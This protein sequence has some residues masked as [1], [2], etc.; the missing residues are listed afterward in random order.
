MLKR[1]MVLCLLLAVPTIGCFEAT[2]ASAQRWILEECVEETNGEYYEYDLLWN[3]CLRKA[4]PPK[5]GYYGIKLVA[6]TSAVPALIASGA[7]FL[8]EDAGAKTAVVCEISGGGGT[9]S[10][11]AEGTVK[12]ITG[13]SCKEDVGECAKPSAKS[14]HLPWKTELRLSGSEVRDLTLSGGS[15]EPGWAIE[16]EVA[17][18]F[19]ITDECTGMT[20]TGTTAVESGIEAT[21]DEHSAAVNCSVGG[22]GTGHVRGQF[23][24]QKGTGGSVLAIEP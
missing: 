15:G 2:T 6:H 14:L 9:V 10:P 23:I 11:G 20:D 3:R 16:C 17:K 7:E 5:T 1:L 13:T 18:I 22:T 21:F 12:E 4:D 8:F 19:K 24:V